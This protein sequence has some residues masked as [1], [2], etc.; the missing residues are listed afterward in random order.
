M[1]LYQFILLLP[2]DPRYCSETVCNLP[3]AK[4][5]SALARSWGDEDEIDFESRG[6]GRGRLGVHAS[7]GAGRRRLPLRS[8]QQL[9]GFG[10]RIR[11]DAQEWQL[12]QHWLTTPIK[13]AQKRALVFAEGDDRCEIRTRISFSDGSKFDTPVDYCGISEVIAT[14][15]NLYSK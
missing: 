12:E 1:N 4:R 7:D 11:D 5:P 8:G 3:A 6:R 10:N 9:G 2:Q 15:E 14:D 13:P